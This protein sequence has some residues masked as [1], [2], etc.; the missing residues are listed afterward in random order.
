MIDDAAERDGEDIIQDVM[1]GIFERSD[2]TDPI[3]DPSAYTYRLLYNRVVDGYRK[4]RRTVSLDTP[5]GAREG[6]LSDILADAGADVHDEVEKKR[7]LQWSMKWR[8]TGTSSGGTSRCERVSGSRAG[9][10]SGS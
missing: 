4:K 1:L 6:T 3:G 10:C 2:V 9:S 5:A 8:N 7:M